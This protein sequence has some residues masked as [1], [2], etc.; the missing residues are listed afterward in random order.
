MPWFYDAFSFGN[1]LYCTAYFNRILVINTTGPF[2]LYIA[3]SAFATLSLLKIY[4]LN[5]AIF[6]VQ[7]RNTS[8]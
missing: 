3:A 1:N 7:G 8:A 5:L 6:Q 4:F 2:M